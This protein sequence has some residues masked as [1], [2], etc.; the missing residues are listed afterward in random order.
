MHRQYTTYIRQDA[1]VKLG[2]IW[3]HVSA[4]TGHLQANSEQQLRYSKNSTQWDPISFTL[5]LDKNL[6]ILTQ[7]S[8]IVWF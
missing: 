7:N 8:G 6:K 1:T 3:L 5:N 2:N 4:V